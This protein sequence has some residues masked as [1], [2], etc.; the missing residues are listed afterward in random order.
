[1]NQTIE[2]I[3]IHSFVNHPNICS[4]YGYFSDETNVY[5]LLELCAD[6]SLY[7]IMKTQKVLP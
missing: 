5:L 3:K 1:M 2:E 7:S 6:K 4:M